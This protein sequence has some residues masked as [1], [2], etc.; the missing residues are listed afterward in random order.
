MDAV[1]AGM[2]A[3]LASVRLQ[4]GA[5]GATYGVLV[6]AYL[7]A[8]QV[9][10]ERLSPIGFL[11]MGAHVLLIGAFVAALVVLISPMHRRVWMLYTVPCMI[12]FIVWYGALFLPFR[13][14]APDKS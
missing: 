4:I 7:I 2:R 11:N 14:S 8:K 13:G 1:K 3:W 5:F 9:I 10:G 6:C 12:L